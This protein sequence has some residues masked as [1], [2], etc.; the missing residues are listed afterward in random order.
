[1]FRRKR[2]GKDPDPGKKKVESFSVQQ[3]QTESRE[4]A[5][6]PAEDHSR[7]VKIL[8]VPK[9]NANLYCIC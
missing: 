1:M 8:S 6:K 5:I 7:S 3:Q 9:F 2:I 4:E